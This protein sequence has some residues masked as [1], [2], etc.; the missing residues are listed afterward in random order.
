MSNKIAF[1]LTF[2]ISMNLSKSVGQV[3]DKPLQIGLIAD[4]QYADKE[5]GK[6]RFYRS[7]IQKLEEAV[8]YLNQESILFNVV[9]GDLVDEGP[10][11]LAPILSRLNELNAPHFNLLGNHDYP[12]EY[13][14]KLFKTFEMDKEYYSLVKEGWKFIFLNSNELSSY[15]VKKGSKLEKEYTKL[16]SVLSTE[17]RQNVQDWNGGIGSKQLRWLEKELN[18]ADKKGLKVIVFSHHPFLPE[19]GL[20]TLNNRV[21]I[22]LFVKHKA[23]KAVLSAHHHPG[24]FEMY[25]SI[26]FITLE[27]M[28]ETKSNAFG[29]MSLFPDKLIIHGQGRMTT[30]EVSLR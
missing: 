16:K 4:I 30:R 1:L 11:D 29:Y 28:V 19:N 22:N 14:N 15:A 6:S 25:K 12:K 9:L 24:N 23:V 21:L 26:P 8:S 2:L 3:Q 27:G 7:S 10:K 5:Y 18:S 20:E 13:Q 17:G